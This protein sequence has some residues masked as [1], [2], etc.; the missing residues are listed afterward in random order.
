MTNILV[1]GGTGFIGIALVKKLHELGHDLK[2]LVRESSN[3]NHFKDLNNIEYV[4]GDLLDFSSLE[5]AVNKVSAIYHLAAYTGIWAKDNSIYYDVNVKGTE[6]IANIA[7]QNNLQLFYVSSFTALGPTPPEPVDETHENETFCMEYEKS[8]CQAKK[9]VKDLIPKGLKVMI[10]YPGIVY[11]PEDFNVFGR[12]FFDVMRGKLFPLGACP[13]KGDSMTCLTYVYDISNALTEVLNREDLLGE[14]FILGGENVR[15]KEYLDLIAK[16]SR[17]K[18][19]RKFPFPI[20][21]AYAWFLEV[22]ARFNMK[23]P[24]LTRSTLKAIKFHRAYSSK[25]A[26][27]KFGYKIT[28]LREGIEETIK[29]YKEYIE[30]GKVK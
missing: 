11:G 28:P 10:F 16:I 6:N 27:D 7:L 5:K 30:K 14:D 23:T 18:K 20:A 24:F 25:K 21:M 15:F 19:A 9:L 2:L 4:I 1:T 22:K 12:M 29:W 3:I 13:G 8:K 17:N 26:I